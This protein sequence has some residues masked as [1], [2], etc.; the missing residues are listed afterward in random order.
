MHEK[1][2]VDTLATPQLFLCINMEIFVCHAA[3]RPLCAGLSNA[4]QSQDDQRSI[5]R[6]ALA[7]LVVSAAKLDKVGSSGQ[8]MVTPSSHTASVN[9]DASRMPAV[10]P[11][12]HV[13]SDG[14]S[15][16]HMEVV[17]RVTAKA[18][19]ENIA[20]DVSTDDGGLPTW[21]TLFHAART[22]DELEGKENTEVDSRWT[23]RGSFTAR[24]RSSFQGLSPFLQRVLIDLQAA[25]AEVYAAEVKDSAD[26]AVA[27]LGD[28][29][30]K[31]CSASQFLHLS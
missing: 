12:T 25:T 3:A 21:T 24:L 1:A 6:A 15:V 7:S 26:G 22:L 11:V 28:S 8:R 2:C 27:G 23:N 18:V 13:P 16:S 9:G 31:G 30:C 14:T 20:N 4:G 17:Q 5:L 29:M 10:L 19:L